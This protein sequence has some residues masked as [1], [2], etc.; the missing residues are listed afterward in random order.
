[1]SSAETPSRG[2]PEKL[3]LSPSAKLL[4]HCLALSSASPSSFPT[5]SLNGTARTTSEGSSSEAGKSEPGAQRRGR[6]YWEEF[7][8]VCEYWGLHQTSGSG[9]PSLSHSL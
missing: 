6:L 3:G 8:G 4:A 7:T 5:C 9:G 1:M 2:S